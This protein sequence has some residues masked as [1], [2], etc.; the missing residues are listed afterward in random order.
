MFNLPAREHRSFIMGNPPIVRAVVQIVFP[1]A[2]RLATP[3]GAAELQD[4]LG[5]LF[6]M[7]P[8]EQDA[9]LRISFGNP[10]HATQGFQFRHADGYRLSVTTENIVLTIDHRY[11]DRAAFANVLETALSAVRQVGKV[12]E[13][14]RVGVRYINAA[15][16]SIGD[17]RTWF[18]PEFTGWAGGEILGAD[19]HRTWVLITQINRDNLD[20][21]ITT[22]VVRYGYVPTGVGSDV[23]VSAAGT[24]PS[25]IADIDLGSQRPAIFDVVALLELFRTINHEVAALFEHTLSD[26]G[27]SHFALAAKE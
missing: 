2:M 9:A 26:D 17:F 11:S 21:P 22:G 25:F 20:S 12:T 4:L 7:E 23:T 27:A 5:G 18:K 3:E 13:Y 14:L 19:S 10:G 16:A 6:Q 1:P 24:H 8:A 15:P